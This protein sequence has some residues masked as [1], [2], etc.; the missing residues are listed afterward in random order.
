MNKFL[1]ISKGLNLGDWEIKSVEMKRK[2]A[3]LKEEE[4]RLGRLYITGKISESTYEQLHGEWQEKLRHTELSL[5]EMERE[6]TTHIDD[7]DMAL[8]LLSKLTTLYQRFE[9]K[10]K[11][12][13][14]QILAKRIMVNPDGEISDHVLN[15]PF[16]YLRQIADEQIS[17]S[18]NLRGS[19]QITV[20]AQTVGIGILT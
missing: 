5:A 11:T 3:L 17:I 8:V 4:A 19:E 7:L 1:Q 16:M 13:L 10:E 18:Q 2:V 6:S 20:G 15:S 9:D 12:K 14:L